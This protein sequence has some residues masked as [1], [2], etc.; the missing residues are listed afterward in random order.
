MCTLSWCILPTQ[1]VL[2]FNRDEQRTRQQAVSPQVF[3]ENGIN[4]IRP[5]DPDGGGTWISTNER[6]LSL[7]LLNYYQ[8]EIPPGKLTSRG[9]LVKSLSK[10]RTLAEIDEVLSR[11]TLNN[12][13]PFSLV[14]FDFESLCG[15]SKHRHSP[16]L[17]IWTGDSL[18]KTDCPL[19]FTSSSVK[20]E[21]VKAKRVRRF[22]E[23]IGESFVLSG[24]EDG[25]QIEHVHHLLQ[26]YHTGHDGTPGYQ[27]VCLHRDD[28]T[29]VSLSQIDVC[30]EKVLFQYYDGSPC[31]LIGQGYS[32][33]TGLAR[34]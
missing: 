25:V 4:I 2:F 13:A 5:H 31:T 6:G 20:F 21:E 18:Q 32:G 10:L 15:S 14:V 28:A 16:Q 7:C 34:N 26:A 3:N 9:L 17:R 22:N 19:P 29:S 24:D 11:E 1:Y 23:D 30:A 8:G 33:R 12:Y 27:S